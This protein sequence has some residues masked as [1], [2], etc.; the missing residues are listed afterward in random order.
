MTHYRSGLNAD[1]K[2]VLSFLTIQVRF[3]RVWPIVFRMV[4]SGHMVDAEWVT[5]DEDKVSQL[6]EDRSGWTLPLKSVE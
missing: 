6:Q 4:T 3:S 5:K 2:Q 1:V